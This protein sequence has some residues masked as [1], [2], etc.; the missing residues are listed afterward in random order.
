[1]ELTNEMLHQIRIIK[2][3]AFESLFEQRINELRSDEMRSLSTRKYLD[4]FC[5]YFWAT[6]PILGEKERERNNKSCSPPS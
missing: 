6:T 3:M 4:A 5:V 2:F 1:M